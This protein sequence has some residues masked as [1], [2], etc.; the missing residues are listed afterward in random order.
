VVAWA[1]D[2]RGK[3]DRRRGRGEMDRRGSKYRIHSTA[4]SKWKS[5]PSNERAIDSPLVPGQYAACTTV[6]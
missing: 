3:M 4:A 5:R 6:S 2:A 1:Y